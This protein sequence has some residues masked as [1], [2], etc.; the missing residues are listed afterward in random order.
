MLFCIDFRR[1]LAAAV[2]ICLGAIPALAVAQDKVLSTEGNDPQGAVVIST[3]QVRKGFEERFPGL[4]V[5]EIST[6]P[7]PG[8]FEIRIGSD[9]L[10][11]DGEVNY[12]LQGSLI[13]AKSRRDL[14]AQRL[15]ALSRVDFSSLPFEAAIKQ[16]RG[17]GSRQMAV[18]ED[19]NC[20]YC[21][22]LHKT[23]ENM[24]DVTIYTFLFPILS[25]DS[26]SRSRNIW[27]AEDRVAAWRGWMLEN[28]HPATAECDTPV[29]ANLALGKSLM[30]TGTPAIFFADGTRVNG[31]LR[32]ADLEAKLS[33][34]AQSQ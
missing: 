12:V 9:L 16:V 13:D 24:D 21:K 3:E 20:G 8:L 28:K 23:L 29:E 26:H 25:E 11:V 6:T 17:D 27:C 34:A 4:G 7:F 2:L 14:T 33:A 31:A 1:I 15:E 22:L 30:V 5:N 19:P 10:Y 32:Q 18:F